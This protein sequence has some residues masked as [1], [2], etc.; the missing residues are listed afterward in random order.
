MFSSAASIWTWTKTICIISGIVC[1]VL[2]SAALYY[3]LEMVLVVKDAINCCKI[4]LNYHLLLFHEVNFSRIEFFQGKK[5]NRRQQKQRRMM[6]VSTHRRMFR[7]KGETKRNW[8]KSY[9]IRIQ[10]NQTQAWYLRSSWRQWY[11]IIRIHIRRTVK[12]IQSNEMFIFFLL[13]FFFIWMQITNLIL[14][15]FYSHELFTRK[16]FVPQVWIAL[17]YYWHRKNKKWMTNYPI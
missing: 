2:G 6:I 3:E 14:E 9:L 4:G 16:L 5:C 13:I 7:R 10:F 17:Y 15:C 1:L 12:W 8:F 11:Q